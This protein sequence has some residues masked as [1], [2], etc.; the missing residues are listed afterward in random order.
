MKKCKHCRGKDGKQKDVYETF[1]SA[2]DTA[3]HI[4]KT[5]G[6]YLNVYK[7]QV[8]NGWHLTSNDSSYENYEK[9]PLFHSSEIPSASYDGSWEYINDESDDNNELVGNIIKITKKKK[10]IKSKMNKKPGNKK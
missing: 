6:V 1:Q 5:R 8:G 10:E 2:L 4:E 9:E 3:N 7:C